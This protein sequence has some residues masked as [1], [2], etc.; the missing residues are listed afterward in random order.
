MEYKIYVEYEKLFKLSMEMSV[1]CLLPYV[2]GDLEGYSHATS[3]K[4]IEYSLAIKINGETVDG[5]KD[6]HELNIK[7]LGSDYYYRRVKS[8]D[9]DTVNKTVTLEV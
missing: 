2:S 7:L 8:V 6:I 9:V 1:G 4:C 3:D 5:Y